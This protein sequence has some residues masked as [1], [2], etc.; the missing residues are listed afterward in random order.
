MH[1]IQINCESFTY[2]GQEKAVLKNLTFNADYGKLTLLSGFSG[3]GKSTLLSLING[4]IPR[5]TSGIFKGQVLING[6]STEG[7]TMSEIAR[8]TAC[9]L[10]NAESQIVNQIV[11]DEIAFTCENFA[12][13]EKEIEAKIE[14]YCSLL[15]LEKEWQTRTLSGGQKQRLITASVLAMDSPI[16][17]FDEPLANLDQ[18]G[19]KELLSIMK[20]LSKEGKA[21]LLVEHRLD[22]VL[23][24]VDIVWQLKNGRTEL[25]NDKKS[26]LAKQTSLIKDS[27]EDCISESK[28]VIKIKDIKKAFGKREILK[29]LSCSINRADRILLLGE[30]GCGKT[31]LLNIIARLLKADSG[32][33]EQYID[34]KLGKKAYKKWYKKVGVVYQNPNY[35]L[36]MPSVKEEILFNS[37]D[38]EYALD[39]A[40]KL[41]LKELFKRHP[42]SLS[43]GQKRR[44]S[45]AAILA[46]KPELLLLDEPTVGQDYE[47]LKS[48]INVI[49]EVHRKTKCTIIS[50]THDFRCASAL[51]DKSFLIENGKIKECGGKELVESFFLRNKNSL[52]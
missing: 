17:I 38:T 20:K 46:Q 28:I 51:C 47:G 26:F 45:I 1:A 29:G 14:K 25:I 18:N 12:I 50:I 27:N 34:T 19:A 44:V 37:D 43:E 48:L 13:P 7:L 5:I 39:I 4:V 15:K 22:I 10:Q 8:K 21:I 23:P 33:I 36:F 6:Q 3:S 16:I 9:V 11:E 32:S 41:G 49:N 42:Q 30:N 31:T 2:N 24:F 40:E 52:I 35:Q